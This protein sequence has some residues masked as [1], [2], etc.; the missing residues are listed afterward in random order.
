MWYNIF[1][2]RHKNGS[3]TPGTGV[4]LRS[5]P[6]QTPGEENH[7][8]YIQNASL[9]NIIYYIMYK[10]FKICKMTILTKHNCLTRTGVCKRNI[11]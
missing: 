3:K 5:L 11:I 10:K 2:N 1:R 8:Y 7:I 9:K 6:T 4:D